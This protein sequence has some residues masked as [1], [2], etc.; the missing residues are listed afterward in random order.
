MAGQIQSSM[1]IFNRPPAISEDT[2]QYTLYPPPSLSD[3]ASVT[4]LA[5][6]VQAH[7]DSLL[8]GFLWH[9]DA[10]EVKVVNSPDNTSSWILEGRMRVGDCVDDEW[11]TVWLLK[12]I[13][14]KWDLAISVFDTDGDFLLIEAAEVLPAWVTPAN[15]ENRVWIYDARLHLI[16]LRHVSPP[17]K[18]RQRRR[19]PGGNA[20]DDE[21][22]NGLGAG[23]DN[24]EFIAVEDALKLV[25]DPSVDTFAPSSVEQVVWK[26]IS[27]YPQALRSH[28]HVTKA[29]LPVDIA[30]A[31]SANPSLTQ[32][33]V[34]TFY[35]RDAAQLRAAHRMNRFPPEPAVLTTVK[36]TRTAYAQ[37]V[38]QKFYPP[39]AFGRWAER[40]GTNEWRWRDTGMKLAC[41]F[42]ILYQESKGRTDA[43]SNSAD[44]IR[45]SAQARKEA[46][47]RNPDYHKYIENLKSAGYFKGEL[48]GSSLWN[49]L[50]NKAAETFV[51]VRRA[52]DATRPSFATQLAAALSQ[53]PP[54]VPPSS[55]DEDPDD[56]LNVDASDFDQLLERTAGSAGKRNTDA[57]KDSQAMDVDGEE[58]GSKK[59]SLEDR[60]TN[61]QAEKLRK[62]A[63]K[64]GDFVEGQG[65]L[66]GARFADEDSSDDE[67]SDGMPS[68]SDDEDE[69]VDVEMD[70]AT[71]QEAMDKLVPGIEPSEYGKMPASFYENSQ[72]VATSSAETDDVETSPEE[73]TEAS[74]ASETAESQPHLRPLRKPLLP[75]DEYDGVIDSDDESDDDE[76]GLGEDEDAEEEDEDRPQ[77]LGEIDIDMGN[78]EEEFLEF[79]RQALGISDEQWGEIVRDRR[80]RGGTSS[81][82]CVVL[83][84]FHHLMKS[85][86]VCSCERYRSRGEAIDECSSQFRQ[87]R[88][89][90]TCK[91]AVRKSGV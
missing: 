10:F 2:L 61:A 30:R 13:S 82:V 84:L 29:W 57:V 8:P 17:S 91:S 49:E 24:D 27:S 67:F 20:S 51:E 77:V 28:V 87:G 3:K 7:V 37:L 69:D 70:Q 80:G 66:D 60:E 65:D 22:E 41:G 75:R 55:I 83:S 15:S 42:E 76:Q 14:A 44:A 54:E 79:A 9:R 62:L 25:S 56:W 21:D 86:S 72:R 78:E 40:E 64:V 26:R 34:E 59:E 48:E 4:S 35:T 58:L 31:L 46:L 85:C 88:F 5:A 11:C 74:G 36:L 23:D 18:R 90:E 47:R 89:G 45:S 71:R 39:K 50:E 68:D 53:A 16:P 63:E 33:P 52:D 73:K 6:C 19:L 38:G 43:G 12:E 81:F 1:D 32:K